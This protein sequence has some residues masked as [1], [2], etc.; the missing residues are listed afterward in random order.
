M[1]K[2]HIMTLNNVRK[3]ALKT[4]KQAIKKARRNKQ[5]TRN[6]QG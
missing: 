4:R 6:I 3:Q 1:N 5:I 2:P